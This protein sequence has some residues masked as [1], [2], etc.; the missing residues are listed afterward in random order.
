MEGEPTC[1]LAENNRRFV[2]QL[3]VVAKARGD[4]LFTSVV[5]AFLLSGSLFGVSIDSDSDAESEELTIAEE[6]AKKHPEGF[7]LFVGEWEPKKNQDLFSK[8][9]FGKLRA[10]VAIDKYSSRK[11]L[12]V[13]ADEK[14][15]GTVMERGLRTARNKSVSFL[16]RKSEIFSHDYEVGYDEYDRRTGRYIGFHKTKTIRETV[17]CVS[18]EI[19]W[20]AN[21]LLPGELEVNVVTGRTGKPVFPASSGWDGVGTVKFENNQ[22]PHCDYSS[23]GSTVKGRFRKVSP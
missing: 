17:E 20:I 19:E 11:F 9:G 8:A 15:S 16:I 4:T 13:Y 7:S 6:V 1:L 3:L 21:P 14:M 12:R 2:F 22:F 5:L 23:Q 10:E 18:E